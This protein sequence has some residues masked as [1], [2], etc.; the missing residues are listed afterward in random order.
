[1]GGQIKYVLGK[2]NSDELNILPAVLDVAADA[3]KSFATIG[4]KRAMES[5]NASGKTARD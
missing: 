3:V 2:W 1:M 5:V 4:L